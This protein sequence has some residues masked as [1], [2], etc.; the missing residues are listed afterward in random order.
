[1]RTKSTLS[2]QNEQYASKDSLSKKSSDKRELHGSQSSLNF[3]DQKSNRPTSKS[4]EKDSHH[5][6][7]ER[8][9]SDHSTAGSQVSQQHNQDKSD[10]LPDQTSEKGPGSPH[11]LGGASGRPGSSRSKKRSPSPEAK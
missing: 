1:L 2:K 10:Q 8:I 9:D 5:P 6:S 11:S 4:S 3:G 7:K